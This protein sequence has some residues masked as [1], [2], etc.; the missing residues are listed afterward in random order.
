MCVIHHYESVKNILQQS[1]VDVGLGQTVVVYT[2]EPNDSCDFS[3]HVAHIPVTQ[4]SQVE[5]VIEAFHRRVGDIS[6]HGFYLSS[7]H[8]VGGYWN[9]SLMYCSPK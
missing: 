1:L 3:Q 9:L 7:R 5:D 4:G 8:V 2:K 6:Y